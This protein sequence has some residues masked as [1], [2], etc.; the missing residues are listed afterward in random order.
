MEPFLGTALAEDFQWEPSEFE[1]HLI[2]KGVPPKED[3]LKIVRPKAGDSESDDWG[4]DSEPDLRSDNKVM[5]PDLPGGILDTYHQEAILSFA[6][7]GRS[8][9]Q[10]V[11]GPS[12]E[13]R[14]WK[15]VRQSSLG[16]IDKLYQIPDPAFGRVRRFRPSRERGILH[17]PDLPLWAVFA[18]TRYK[19]ILSIKI[20]G[21]PIGKPLNAAQRNLF[22]Q[23]K[24]KVWGQGPKVPVSCTPAGIRWYNNVCRLYRDLR[25]TVG[26]IKISGATRIPKEYESRRILIPYLLGFQSIGLKGVSDDLVFRLV[27][28]V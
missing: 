17:L 27:R 10:R 22:F 23:G 16:E 5:L 20:T 8:S 14:I 4:I 6:R 9:I 25:F 12:G 15:T 19:E 21:L 1:A 11:F 13:V 7:R 2:E 3:S 24:F 18:Y 26:K 28:R